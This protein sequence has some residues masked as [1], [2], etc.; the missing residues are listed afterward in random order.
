LRPKVDLALRA[1]KAVSGDDKPAPEDP[2]AA[3][4][5]RSPLFDAAFYRAALAARGLGLDGLEPLEHYRRHGDAARV[6]PN[7]LFDP[8][9]YASR[10]PDVV[11]AGVNLLQHYVENGHREGRDPHP[12]VDLKLIREQLAADFSGDPLVAYLQSRGAE[13]KPHRLGDDRPALLIYLDS[14]PGTINPSADFDGAGYWRLYPDARGV[15]PLIHF[16]GVGEIEGRRAPGDRGPVGRVAGLIEAAGRLD[17]DVVKPFADVAATPL[18]HGYEMARREFR[19]YRRLA[20][21]AGRHAYAH[22]IMT[23]W[24]KRGGADRAVIELARGLLESDPAVRVM[25]V[26]TQRDEVEAL[27]W[28]ASSRRLAVARIAGEVGDDHDT[29]VAF[30]NFLRFAGCRHLYV[31]NSRFGWDLLDKYGPTLR[32]LMRL[33]GFAFCQDYDDQGRRA[34]YAWTRLNRAVD[35]LH[36]LVSDNSRTIHEFAADH[37]FDA[38]DLAKFFWLPLPADD[39]LDGVAAPSAARNLTLPGRR[40]RVFWA[41]RFVAQ[42]GLDVAADVARALPEVDV[43]AFGGDEAPDGAPKNLLASGGFDDFADLPLHEAAL[44]LHTARWEGL[45]NVLLEAGAAG[46]PIIA[47]DVGGVGDLVDE[48]TGWLVPREADAAAFAAA[49]RDALGRP[50]EALERAERM[51]ARIRERHDRDVFTQGVRRLIAFGAGA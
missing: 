31:V 49:I 16:V 27:D 3:V 13:L 26:C 25:I 9:Y 14:D 50:R 42:K 37:G 17:P 48:T 24:L 18:M 20:K 29:Y 4:L 10:N 2:V 39:R 19:L 28:A 44:F 36:A 1:I 33:Y 5:R 12:L 34:G 7:P 41:G 38:D 35:S 47:R 32:S 46:L 6:P 45:P 51:R 23:P 40:P 21:A 11:R 22:V 43:C 15:N 8:R 30:C